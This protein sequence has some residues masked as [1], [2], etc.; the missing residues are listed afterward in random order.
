MRKFIV[1]YL[2]LDHICFSKDM[3]DTDSILADLETSG[4]MKYIEDEVF[5]KSYLVVFHPIVMTVSSIIITVYL[6]I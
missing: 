2:G 3:G 6:F 4:H 1:K 5:H